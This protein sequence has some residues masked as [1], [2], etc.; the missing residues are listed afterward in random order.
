MK[1]TI[2]EDGTAVCGEWT[3]KPVAT[4]KPEKW[5]WLPVYRLMRGRQEIWM[6]FNTP[7]KAMETAEQYQAA[8]NAGAA[9][10]R[11]AC[12]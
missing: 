3:V 12:R 1:W 4:L 8:I 7:E 5:K 9:A 10:L 6:E 11:E 2:T